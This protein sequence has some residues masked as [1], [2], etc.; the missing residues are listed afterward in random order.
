MLT[1][2][3]TTR[4]LEQSGI[5][6]ALIPFG[7]T[8]QFG[9]YLP[10]HIDCL[11]AEKYAQCYGE[12]LNAYVLPVIPFNTSEEHAQFRGTITL[13]PQL[14]SM[15]TEEIINVLMKQNFKKF[16]LASGHGG[17]NWLSPC[18]KHLN[19]KYPTI[20]LV[21]AHANTEQPWRSASEVA[22]FAHNND[23]HGG[24]LGLCTALYL[25]PELIDYEAIQSFGK[26]VPS[27]R[28]QFMDYMGWERL[29]PD[30]SWGRFERGATISKESLAERG[31]LFWETFIQ[32]QSEVLKEHL[33]Q[34]YHLKFGSELV[35][36]HE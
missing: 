3:N 24:L 36:P 7:S 27:E 10:M 15:M 19:Y 28:N 14:L 30:G 16:V 17:A 4:Q 29:T 25:C 11:L 32:R 23:I 22:D 2:R 8:E 34:A 6:I 18:I 35:P 31:K 20:L 13:S 5:D 33:A 1:S 26:A 9:P 21:H 12:A